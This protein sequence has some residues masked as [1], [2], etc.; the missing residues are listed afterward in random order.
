MFSWVSCSIVAL[1]LRALLEAVLAPSSPEASTLSPAQSRRTRLTATNACDG[2]CTARHTVP[3]EPS[4][5]FDTSS[6]SSSG[7]A[8][9]T[10]PSGG[11]TR[12]PAASVFGDSA[13]R[14]SAAKDPDIPSKVHS[15]WKTTTKQQQR[16][17][18]KKKT[19]VKKKK[20]RTRKE[21][22]ERKTG[23]KIKE[24]GGK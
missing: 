17:N 4:P 3:K 10:V 5:I 19:D 1:S 22:K 23:H 7:R 21:Q 12:Y 14:S 8:P 16:N 20:E 6:S 2:R 9:N 15:R 13:R 24:G 11:A 18:N